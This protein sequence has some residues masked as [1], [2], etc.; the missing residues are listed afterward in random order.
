MIC[1]FWYTTVQFTRLKSLIYTNLDRAHEKLSHGQA[2][3][4]K[5]EK[6]AN[7]KQSAVDEMTPISTIH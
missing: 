2:M 4:Y 1:S 3:T 7:S 6:R 5:L